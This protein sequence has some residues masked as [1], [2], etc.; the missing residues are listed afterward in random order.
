MVLS[1]EQGYDATTVAQIAT[2]AGVT[3]RTF[4]RHFPDKCDAFFPDNTGLLALLVEAVRGARAAG[5]GAA[6]AALA[7]V[8]RLADIVLEEPERI[9]LGARVIPSVPVLAG[10]DLYRQAQIV[11]AVAATLTDD[12]V[13]ALAARLAAEQAVGIWRVAL[14]Q[15]AAAPDEHSLTDVLDA[16]SSALRG[17]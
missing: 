1:A 17:P 16:T 12:G 8:H 15:W 9:L 3:E 4:Y 14:R 11:D 5:V 13:D 2:A 7:A 6:P 10:R